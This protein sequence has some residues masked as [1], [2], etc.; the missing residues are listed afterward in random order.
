MRLLPLRYPYRT[1]CWPC[2]F[3]SKTVSEDSVQ[4][5]LPRGTQD[6]LP[7]DQPYWRFVTSTAQEMARR[8]AYDRID[9]PVFEQC[10]FF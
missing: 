4:F 3:V 8:F 10:G 1:L 2:Y 6:I 9:T 7:E 5:R